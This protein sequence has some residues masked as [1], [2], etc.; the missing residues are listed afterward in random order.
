MM[1]ETQR[2]NVIDLMNE[3]TRLR[4]ALQRLHDECCTYNDHGR[5]V[6]LNLGPMIEPSEA[7]VLE[8]RKVLEGDR[9]GDR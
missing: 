6:R 4:A 9:N 3:N 7:A 8:A 5:I 1:N 2:D